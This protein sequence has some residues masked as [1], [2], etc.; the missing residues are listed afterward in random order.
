MKFNSFTKIVFFLP[1]L[2][3]SCMQ[4]D[5]LEQSLQLAGDNREE[6][7]R[8]LEH[9]RNDAEKYAAAAFLI[10]N[11]PAHYSYRDSAAMA[12]YYDL[13]EQVLACDTLTPVQQR[14]TLK[15]FCSNEI[16]NATK[17]VVSDVKLIRS[18]FLIYSIDHAFDKWRNCPWSSHLNFDEFCEW[19]LP[20]KVEEC[21]EF[22][23][24]RDTLQ[25]HFSD[26]IKHMIPDDVEYNTCFK[27][28]DFVRNELL[29]KVTM[30]GIYTEAG[31][32]ILKA[33]LLP[34][35]TYGRCLDYVNLGVMTFRSFGLPVI[36][37]ETPYW[38]RYRA[39][40]TWYT[41]L[42]DRGQELPAEWDLGSVPGWQFF[43]F[44][45][46][47]KVYRSTYAINMD[48]LE[49]RNRS[50]Y[51]Y[52]FSLCRKDVTEKY[53]NPSTVEIPVPKYLADGSRFKT[54]ES[55]AY[56]CTFCG[57]KRDWNIVDFGKIKHGK[58]RFEKMGRNVLYI[59]QAYDGKG[60][61]PI[62]R[63]F[64]LKKNGKVE[65]VET[66]YSN[67]TAVEL[68]RKYYESTNVVD[69]RRRILG[70]VVQCS[71]TE[72]F[73][74][75]KTVYSV[76]TVIIPDKIPV[77]ADRP[78]RYWR[79]LAADGTYGSIAELGFFDSSGAELKGRAIGCSAAS[80][81]DISKAF[82][83]DRL[84]NFET[85]SEEAPNNAW[86]GLDMGSPTN[87]AYVRIVP[88]GDENDIIPGDEYELRY[89]GAY[90]SWMSTGKL[91]A[92]G[93]SLQYDSIPTGALLWLRDHSRGWDE[94]PF[95][96]L[97]DKSLIWW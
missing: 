10:A 2:F 56:I 27:T 42:G 81:Q 69:K 68:H 92:D 97:E 29:R 50:V 95:I 90:N 76:D 91:T 25:C 62:C 1:V 11:M 5:M 23:Y 77:K 46:I 61:V 39:G 60:L 82:D 80:E 89:W 65:Y 49:Y 53:M 32:P 86:V 79:Y 63:P 22:D 64:V 33:T 38:G 7:E 74:Y 75:A 20:Y 30:Y 93:N 13:A 16:P 15:N 21:Q 37:D 45:R 12:R 6:L 34:K 88:R 87:V 52:P 14:D 26:D 3:W 58:V 73:K 96:V 70:A 17:S 18:D 44:E 54:V 71:N 24:W 83:G 51:K 40:H 28:L 19:L 72:D 47:P 67:F 31:Y 36:K 59:V 84:T 66:D 55:Y 78:Y 8:V 41:V 85:E 43:P 48:V 94:R 4:N 35:Q 9:Y 57:G